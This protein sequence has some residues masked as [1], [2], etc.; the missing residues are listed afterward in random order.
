MLKV[1]NLQPDT[2]GNLEISELDWMLN[3][4]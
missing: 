3:N 2:Y 1:A 4:N